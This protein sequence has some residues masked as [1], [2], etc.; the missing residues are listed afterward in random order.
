MAE[1]AEEGF[2]V[3]TDYEFKISNCKLLFKDLLRG[4]EGILTSVDMATTNRHKSMVCG[5]K[6]F[7]V[8]QKHLKKSNSEKCLEKEE[9]VSQQFKK[10]LFVLYGIKPSFKPCSAWAG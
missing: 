2:S 1:V 9:E 10:F 7:K 4:G 3:L 5:C 8:C 6:E